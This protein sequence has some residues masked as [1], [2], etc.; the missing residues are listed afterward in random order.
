MA[1]RQNT[2]LLKRSNIIGKIPPLSGLTLGEMA[3]NTADA[4]LYSLYTSGS[5][6]PSEVRQIGW[7][8]ISRTGDTVFGD[9]AISGSSLPSGYALSVTGDTNFVG[10]IYVE[11]D[12]NYDGNLTVSGTT[13]LQGL[14]ATTISATTIGTSG[15]CIDDIYVS[16][17][18]SCSPLNINPL[19]EGNVYFGSTSGVTIDL[20]NKRI[21]IGTTTPQ[22]RLESYGSAGNFSVSLDNTAD[23]FTSISGGT[24]DFTYLEART[25]NTNVVR[26]GVRPTGDTL[27][28]AYGKQGDGF[29]FGSITNNGL[30]IISTPGTGTEDYIRFYAGQNALPANTPDIHIQGSGSTRGYVGINNN[31][32]TELLHLKSAGAS[33]IRIEADTDDT[34]E[35]DNAEILMSQDGGNTKANISLTPDTNNDLMIGVNAGAGTTPDIRFNTKSDGLTFTTSADTKVIIKN[36]G[37]VGIGIN[38][39]QYFL[40]VFSGSSQLFYNPTSS[41]GVL[42]VSGSTNLP[43]Y[44]VNIPAFSGKLAASATFGIRAWDDISFGGY[45]K[46]GDT[47]LYSSVE[48][49][50]LN[51][52]SAPGSGTEDYIR[53]FA[54]NVANT[55]PDIYVQ[56]SGVT[57]GYVGIG[58]ATP[59][60]NLDVS[61]NTIISSGLSASTVT[62]TTQPTSGYTSTQILMRNSTSGQVEI[63]DSTSPS[64]YNYGM[65]YAMTTFNYLT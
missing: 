17:I 39:P 14:S 3:L 46:V 54:G 42:V 33:R 28:G 55:T 4:K 47:H 65:T 23:N 62:I 49:N 31:N 15:D 63:T 59:R 64:I 24:N 50:G 43:R 2:L 25:P 7:D 35:P 22:Y 45:G 37:K 26:V 52:V 9:F 16:N 13:F 44:A 34:P 60:E 61:G 32:P 29:L 41:G 38:D 58:T 19:D 10:D 8:R 53:F 27:N 40:Q 1:N 20:S 21:G 18:H 12:L 51:I 36:D 57:R 5:P 56:G 6:S 48:S 11:G 30:N